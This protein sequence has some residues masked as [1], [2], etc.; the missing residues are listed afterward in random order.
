[1]P[2]FTF[3]SLHVQTYT[4]VFNVWTGS[5]SLLLFRIR[6]ANVK[7]TLPTTMTMYALDKVNDHDEELFIP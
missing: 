6:H 7:Q 4:F 3:V 1:M 5:L 2:L